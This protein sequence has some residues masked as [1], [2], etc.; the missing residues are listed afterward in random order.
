MMKKLFAIVLACLFT[1]S[2]H[3][4]NPKREMRGA[5]I[6]CVN[7]QFMGMG[8]EEMQSTLKQHLDALAKCKVNVVMFQVRPEADA[9][10]QSSYEP[11]SRFLTGVQG[12]A[13]E[14]FWDPLAWMVAECHKRGM[15]LH[16]WINPYRAKTK[17]TTQLST[18]H[19]YIKNP[20]RFFEYDNLLI[21]DPALPE[22]RQYI[23]DVVKDIVTRYDVDGLHIDDYF[24]PYPAGKPIPDDASYQLYNNGIKDRGDWR[25]FNVNLLIEMMHKTL[26]ETKPWVKF[27]ISPFGIYH[28]KKDDGSLVPGSETGG[29]QNYDDLY[30]DVLYWVEKGW[31]DY[32][33]PQVY[34]QIGHPTADYDTLVKWWNKYCTKCALVIGQDIDRS[35]KYNDF[36]AKMQ[37]QRAQSNV[38]GSVLWYSAAVVK[39]TADCITKLAGNYHSTYALQPSMPYMDNKSPGKVR[40]VKA[41]WMDD[42][43]YFLFWTAPRAKHPMD[44]AVQY[45]VYRFAKGEKVNLDD[46]AHI[47]TVTRNTFVPLPF[48]TAKDKYTYVVTALDRVQNESKGVKK[49]VKL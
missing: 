35:E 41:M 9:L 10:Y 15:E 47:V 19:P 31:V 14:P 11:W 27:G 2:S 36:D 32:V 3:S 20:E 46:P 37:L 48:A 8:T 18:K 38:D 44:E 30:A 7:G 40:K 21:F 26:R 1:L 16:A 13:P 34:W 33:A 17:G 6:Q 28:N 4:Q 43:G 25:R 22:N 5:W 12:Q 42:K 49:T 45:V 39:N 24:Y 29:L 23:C